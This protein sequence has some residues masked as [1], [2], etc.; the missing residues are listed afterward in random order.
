MPEPEGWEQLFP[1]TP[2]AVTTSSEVSCSVPSNRSR[3]FPP[4]IKDGR[5]ERLRGNVVELRFELVGPT[6]AATPTTLRP[7]CFG[8]RNLAG[9]IEANR[10]RSCGRQIGM[11][12]SYKWPAIID[13]HNDASVVTDL[14][15]RAERQ[16][17]VRRC[18]R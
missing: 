18:H 11:P 4:A 8:Q 10:P 16:G 17:A 3:E 1:S 15:Q 14:N 13:A 9:L 12:P 6:R 2:L 7:L 5:A